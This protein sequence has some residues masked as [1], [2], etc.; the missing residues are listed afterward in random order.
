[1]S[2]LQ[3][4]QRFLT[5][6]GMRQNFSGRMPQNPAKPPTAK[7]VKKYVKK[8][9]KRFGETKYTP[10]VS[11]DG[12]A[13]VQAST[14]PNST[15]LTNIGGGSTVSTR[16]GNSAMLRNIQLNMYLNY[17]IGVTNSFVRIVVFIDKDP[18][19]GA[20]V[21]WSAIFTA[22]A[23]AGAN[24][25]IGTRNTA[26]IDRFR[27]LRDFWL[28]PYNRINGAATTLGQ[29]HKKVNIRFKK[30]MKLKWTDATGSNVTNPHVYI[31]FVSNNPVAGGGVQPI[32]RMESMLS[33]KDPE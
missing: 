14:N 1:M 4:R 22:S 29:W 32:I 30:G 27:I 6:S 25:F 24:D 28:K 12:T 7:A 21:S 26:L 15:L 11:I 3:R 8:Q 5:S 9:L 16:V 33:F 23:A 18:V 13:I 20:P 2:F 17:P 10:S 19:I 31:V